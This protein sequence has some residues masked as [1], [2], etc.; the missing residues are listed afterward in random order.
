MCQSVLSAHRLGERDGTSIYHPNAAMMILRKHGY[1][2]QAWFLRDIIFKRVLC[3]LCVCL[4]LRM[5]RCRDS[6]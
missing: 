3:H 6:V 5:T 4:Q 2:V 1:N